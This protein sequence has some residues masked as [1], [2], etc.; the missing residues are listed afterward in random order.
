MNIS[1]ISVDQQIVNKLCG[2]VEF[3]AIK[4]RSKD[5]YAVIF[6]FLHVSR[7]PSLMF[8]DINV[9]V[10]DIVQSVSLEINRNF[11]LIGYKDELNLY[12]FCSVILFKSKKKAKEYARLN[13]RHVIKI[14]KRSILL[15]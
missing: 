1:G 9:S 6:S 12:Y 2:S 11:G 5:K 4:D 3:T 10:R 13:N 8:E 7:N 15:S 14:T